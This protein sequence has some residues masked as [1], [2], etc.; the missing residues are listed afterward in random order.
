MFFTKNAYKYTIL[1]CLC[2]YYMYIFLHTK[3]YFNILGINIHFQSEYAQFFILK[4]VKMP[5][6]C[7]FALPFRGMS[8]R[9]AF[10][11]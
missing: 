11:Y 9:F 10:M 4:T 3:A 8:C 5:Q 1:V 6:I 7:N 2:Q